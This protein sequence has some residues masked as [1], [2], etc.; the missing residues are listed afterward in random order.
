M[1]GDSECWFDHEKLEVYREA[2]GFVAWPSVML[3]QK[4][5]LGDVKEQLDPHQRRSH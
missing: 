5:R 3:E 1:A 4:V 2:I